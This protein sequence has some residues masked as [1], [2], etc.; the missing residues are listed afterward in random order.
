M[1]IVIVDELLLVLLLVI[2]AA[3][4]KLRRWAIAFSLLATGSA[5][6][7]LVVLLMGM[8][9]RGDERPLSARSLAAE[10][11]AEAPSTN[12]GS[13]SMIARLLRGRSATGMNACAV[14]ALFSAVV[15]YYIAAPWIASHGHLNYMDALAE[16]GENACAAV[17]QREEMLRCIAAFICILLAFRYVPTPDVL[18]S[19]M[20]SLSDFALLKTWVLPVLVLVYATPTTAI[21]CSLWTHLC[22]AR[23]RLWQPPQQV[24]AVAAKRGRRRNGGG[25]ARTA[26]AHPAPSPSPPPLPPPPSVPLAATRHR[27]VSGYL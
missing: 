5:T 23:V 4:F 10:R 1:R 19:G 11:A 26:K 8:Y 13:T 27:Q 6:C 15:P 14:I 9:P 20:R 12:D 21:A 7:G 24:A 3:L 2:L 22:R 25:G 17:V 16:S 18:P